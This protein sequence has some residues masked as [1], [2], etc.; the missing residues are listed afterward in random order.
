MFGPLQIWYLSLALFP[1][2]EAEIS[3]RHRTV[4]FATA[5]TEWIVEK[6]EKGLEVFRALTVYQFL[7]ALYLYLRVL[8]LSLPPVVRPQ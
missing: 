2:G 4:L 3:A 8:H 5:V 1:H 6:A 7:K